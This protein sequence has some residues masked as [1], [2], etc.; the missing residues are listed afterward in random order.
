[1]ASSATAIESVQSFRGHALDRAG[2]ELTRLLSDHWRSM[3]RTAYRHLGNEADAEDAVQDALLSAYKNRGQFRGQAQ[4]S[5]WLTAIV[6]NSARMQLRRRPRQ[7]YVA[8]DETPQEGNAC[9]L[10]ERLADGGPGPEEMCGRN[11]LTE[12]VA[13]LAAKLSPSVR[14]T[15]KMR[16]VDGLTI[17]ETAHILG[18]AEGTVKARVARART[19]LRCLMR[20]TRVR[21]SQPTPVK[22]R[23]AKS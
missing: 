15:F 16:E 7:T 18:V 1:M 11:E 19:K 17:R 5:T 22:E 8:L 23:A 20:K 3:Y 2:K 6:I 9:P 13:R 12:H 10:S 14:A 21:Q 4:M